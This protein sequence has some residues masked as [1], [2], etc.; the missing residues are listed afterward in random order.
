LYRLFWQASYDGATS[1]PTDAGTYAVVVSLTHDDYQADPIS[2][3][4]VIARASQTI[5][6]GALPGRTYGDAP[7]VLD[8]TAS[9]GLPVTFRI[10][11]GPA[12]VSG[13]TL[14]ISGAGTVVVAADQ[15]GD[16]NHDSAPRV[17]RSFVVAKAHA[18]LTL[19]P[20]S[21]NTAYDRTAHTVVVTTD[22]TGLD[23][24]SIT[25]NGSAV[26]PTNA[27]S[28]AVAVSLNN[29][30]YEAA[31]ATGT[32]AIA[33][34]SALV[35]LVDLH[36]V[37]D[38]ATKAPTVLTGPAGLAFLLACTQNGIKVAPTDAGSYDVTATIDDTNYEGSAAGTLIIDKA[39]PTITW[40]RPADIVYGT[41]LGS[42][43]L[44]ATVA[45]VAGG[46]APGVLSYSPVAG[47]VL[48]AGAWQSLTVTAAETRNYRPATKTVYIDVLPASLIIRAADASRSYGD[49]NPAFSGTIT[50]LKN[51]D[52][53]TASC[54]SSAVVSS[55]VGSYEIVPSV[56]EPGNRLSN[57]D[58]SLVSGTLAVTPA[59]LT[60]TVDDAWRFTG[61]PNPA[62]TGQISPTRNGDPIIAVYGTTAD[63]SG[64]IGYYPIVPVLSG[65]KLANYEVT[66]VTGTLDV[67][68]PAS[69]S[70][71]V[72]EDLNN[73]G[74]IDLGER[75]ILGVVVQLDG[76]DDLGRAI[77]STQQTDADGAYVFPRLRPGQYTIAEAQP[78]GYSQ[79]TNR[80]GSFG[81][82]AQGDRFTVEIPEELARD[83]TQLANGI[84]YNFAEF[85]QVG[86]PI[87]HGQTAGIGFWNNKNGQ[88]LI[89][90]LNGGPTATQLGN[91]LAESFPNLFGAEAASNNLAGK[92]NAQ[93]AAFFQTRFVLKGVKLDA[94]VL[95]TAFSVY[96]T[97]R[98]LAS[99]A[100]TP[101]GFVVSAEGTGA[102]MVDV[103]ANGTAFDVAN[104]TV[105]TVMDVLQA[106]ARKAKKGV[107]FDGNDPLR[108]MAN[109]VFS[110][111]NQLGDIG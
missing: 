30:N 53:I 29:P 73:N 41:G 13:S 103:G 54:S 56:V 47:T 58:V 16:G 26:A 51:G 6:F 35:S 34:A 12:T 14:T 43:Q 36:Q 37:Y 65:E 1:P 109:A 40:A 17:E 11:S 5:S 85:P 66:V 23:G 15:A 2:G 75:G 39:T 68:Q 64:P 78:A 33:K 102:A 25:Y 49:V 59:P 69:L 89:K 42:E 9:S 72:F 18:T 70:G 90:C 110:D 27:G 87:Q 84:N 46:S 86:N 8:A 80:I 98:S 10:L 48:N 20:A 60:V 99:T 19:N 97:T 44:N 76:T 105:M 74:E 81:G 21:L 104:G 3:T 4:L 50:G 31:D 55:P 82:T 107:L 93:V 61:E 111:I 106:T 67:I 32:L 28:Y 96:V 108:K 38:G 71:T 95:A 57:Y 77:H 52:S 91:W 79:G 88:A 100:A 92:T 62:F 45:G 22:P 7:F 101:Y 83:I 94:Q 63:A 24:V